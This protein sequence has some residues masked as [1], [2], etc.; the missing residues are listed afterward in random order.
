MLFDCSKDGDTNMIRCD[1]CPYCK[2]TYPD[3]VDTFGNHFCICGMGGNMVYTQPRKEKR[4]SGSGYIHY[5]VSSCGIF[6]TV[7]DAL[8]SMTEIERKRYYERVNQNV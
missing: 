7:E 4:Y 2:D 3:K 8:A 5:G 6:E 1:T